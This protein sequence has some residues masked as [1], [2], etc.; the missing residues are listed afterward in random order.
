[1]KQLEPHE[2]PTLWGIFEGGA[3]SGIIAGTAMMLVVMWGT[4]VTDG[5]SFVSPLQRIAETVGTSSVLVGALLHYVASCAFGVVFAA[6]RAWRKVGKRRYP[7]GDRAVAAG[8]IYALA[9]WSVMT[10]LVVPLINPSL[11][12]LTELVPSFWFAAHMVF[13]VGLLDTPLLRR[14]YARKHSPHG[15]LPPE[16]RK[17]A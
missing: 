15:D 16:E 13:G 12:E 14:R 2:K 11:R 17:I 4:A 1:M 3:V 7:V 8:L 9:I 5:L 10:F 6:T